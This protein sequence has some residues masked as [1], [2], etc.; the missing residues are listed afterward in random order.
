MSSL[1]T[2]AFLAVSKNSAAS[3]YARHG[4]RSASERKRF[5]CASSTN[6]FFFKS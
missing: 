6:S 3:A 4:S 1:A 2:L 5:A